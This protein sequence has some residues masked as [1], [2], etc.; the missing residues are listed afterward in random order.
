MLSNL[1]LKMKQN[2]RLTF[3]NQNTLT[4]LVIDVLCRRDRIFWL[5]FRL[6]RQLDFSG[7][8]SP[9]KIQISKLPPT[10]L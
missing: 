5:I 1:L 2:S 4:E 3:E 6:G 9:L 7:L 8:I 10:N